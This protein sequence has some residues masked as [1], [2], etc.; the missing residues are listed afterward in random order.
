MSNEPQEINQNQGTVSRLVHDKT[1]WQVIRY[2][3]VGVM[4]TLLTLVVIY[5]LKSF[6]GVNLWVSNAVGYVAGFVNSFLWNKL[7]VF[8]SQRHFLRESFM[9]GVGFLLC[10]GLQFVATW[11]LTYQTPL[12]V[13]EWKFLGLTF[14]GYA[15]ATLAGMVIYT[16]A[17]FVYNRCVTFKQ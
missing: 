4:N 2:G 7:W 17:N 8:K 11:L 10:Y 16:A 15:I 13:L 12:R 3:M 14:S 9:F 1:L 5:V 6:L